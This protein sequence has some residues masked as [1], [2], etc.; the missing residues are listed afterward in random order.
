[1]PKQVN[2][3]RQLSATVF[4]S[5]CVGTCLPHGVDKLGQLVPLVLWAQRPVVLVVLVDDLTHWVGDPHLHLKS[6]EFNGYTRLVSQK[7]NTR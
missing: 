2:P 1:M 7:F 4:P 5:Y 3:G 6:W